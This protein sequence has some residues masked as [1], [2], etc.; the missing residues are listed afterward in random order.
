MTHMLSGFVTICAK[1]KK[2]RNDK[3]SWLS[4]EEYAAQQRLNFHQFSHGL[5]PNCFERALQ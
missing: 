5:C 4:I 1:C 3:E 2:I